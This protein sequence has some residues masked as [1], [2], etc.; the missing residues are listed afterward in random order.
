M[1]PGHPG[2]ELDLLATVFDVARIGICV[3]DDAGRF[4]RVNPAFCQMVDYRAEQ[5]VGQPYSL[6]APDSVVSVQDKFLR[7]ILEDS[8]KIPREW[9]IRRA[10]QSLLDALVSF[11][12]LMTAV[13]LYAADIRLP[14]R[15]LSS[16]S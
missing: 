10:D 14:S 1:E 12:S 4:A 7:A 5:L 13:A 8:P 3:I 6:C 15:R 16:T 11:R 9:Q 2:L